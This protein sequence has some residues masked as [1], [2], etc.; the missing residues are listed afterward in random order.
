M[1]SSH[2]CTRQGTRQ[3]ALRTHLN[4]DLKEGRSNSRLSGGEDKLPGTVRR[5]VCL[6]GYMGTSAL[7]SSGDGKP[8]DGF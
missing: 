5:P 2:R 7:I 8:L 6:R 3:A 4:E 1:Q